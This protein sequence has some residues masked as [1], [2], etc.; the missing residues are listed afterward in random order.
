MILLTTSASP[1]D[2]HF[3]AKKLPLAKQQTPFAKGKNFYPCCRHIL[4]KNWRKNETKVHDENKKGN[5]NR[6][7]DVYFV[8]DNDSSFVLLDL[9]TK[10]L[11]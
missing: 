7:V 4:L 6:R 5:N 8:G 9:I 2:E 10:I 3:V 1:V 11:G